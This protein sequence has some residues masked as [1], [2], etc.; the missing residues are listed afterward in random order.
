[1]ENHGKPGAVIVAHSRAVAVPDIG[2]DVM[3]IAA[4]RHEGRAAAPPRQVEADRAAIEF[5]GLLDTADAQM[6]VADAQ[7]VRRAG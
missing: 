2:A 1:M 7:T 3:V 4:G 5:L 6:D